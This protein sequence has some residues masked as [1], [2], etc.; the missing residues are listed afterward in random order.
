MD[1]PLAA[2]DDPAPNSDRA[3]FGEIAEYL[4]SVGATKPWD[5]TRSDS[6][7]DGS[8]GQ[9]ATQ[10][11]E[12]S[13]GVVAAPPLMVHRTAN[14]Q[15]DVRRARYGFRNYVQALFTAGIGGNGDAC[16]IALATHSL[17]P[18]HRGAI[19]ERRFRVPVE[20]LSEVGQ[21]II[22]T[23]RPVHGDV[24]DRDHPLVGG[25]EWPGDF[26]QW[27]VKWEK[28]A[29]KGGKNNLVIPLCYNA[30]WLSDFKDIL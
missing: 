8:V 5:D 17:W 20:F 30:P 12:A 15:F 29:L 3:K 10:L 7:W 4:R 26:R 28:P 25:I 19:K 14:S 22:D 13:L 23:S 9:L 6:F 1:T 11:V 16:E 27:L 2:A 21:R 24:L 18:T